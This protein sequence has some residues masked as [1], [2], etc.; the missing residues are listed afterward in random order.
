MALDELDA[1][2]PLRKGKPTPEE[3]AAIRRALE[4]L[5]EAGRQWREEH[6]DEYDENNPPSKAWQDELYDEHGL[7]K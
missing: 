3:T 6:P 2:T 7:P 5:S 1:K 4:K